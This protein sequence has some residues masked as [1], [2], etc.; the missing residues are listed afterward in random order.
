MVEITTTFFARDRA[1][2]RRW[3]RANHGSKPEIW[4]IFFKK[5]VDKPCVSYDEA[6]E[7][8]LCFGWI[9]GTSH[10]VDDEKYAQRF[11]PR[12]LRSAWSPSNRQ[13]VQSMIEQG[14][15]TDA[16]LAAIEAAKKSGAWDKAD[17]RAQ[18]DQL[19]M[20][21]DLHAA[22]SR[23]KKAR[24]NFEAFAPSYRKLYLAWLLAAK[25]EETRSKRVRII[26]QR[27]ADNKKPGIDM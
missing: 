26:V 12:K 8:A 13:R 7:E 1:A 25:R 15:M 21:E 9:D 3:L 27:A 16:G 11:S 5:H 17:W 4:L 6:V 14:L 18:A 24:E 10:R 2:W 19:K 22:L 20:P 23:N